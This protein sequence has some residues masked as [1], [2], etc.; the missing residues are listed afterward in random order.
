MRKRSLTLLEVVIALGLA[1]ILLTTL[2]GFY[3]Q[4]FLARANIQKNKETV[5]QRVWVQQRLAQVF[6][7]AEAEIEEDKGL[8]FYTAEHPH[9]TGPAL[10]F[11]YDHGMDPDPDYCGTLK[12]M[13]YLTPQKELMLQVGPARK[14]VLL[15]G[16][17]QLQFA[18]FDPKEKIWQ[19]GWG[20]KN[21]VLPPMVKLT[22]KTEKEDPF[23]FF[24]PG[25]F[26]KIT[27]KKK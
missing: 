16:A 20:E 1:A 4:L 23:V 24:L 18:F 9:A 15:Q 27:Y 2:F 26:K 6:E 17:S 13:L 7:K 3:R 22:I 12:A 5:L 25:A 21:E 11:Y 10:H 14:E 19:T 8:V